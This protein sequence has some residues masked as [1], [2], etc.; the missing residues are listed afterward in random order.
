M[1]E[2]FNFIPNPLHFN[3]V[4]RGVKEGINLLKT[5]YRD[6]EPRDIETAMDIL[7]ELTVLSVCLGR[8]E[9]REEGGLDQAIES[10]T[11][12][13]FNNKMQSRE[14]TAIELLKAVECTLVQIQ[15]A[16]IEELRDITE[17]ERRA[18]SILINFKKELT[19]L[20][21]MS[22]PEW[23]KAAWEIE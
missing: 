20:I 19:N 8:E 12:Y 23:S 9:L 5:I 21:I 6:I 11:R 18:L 16:P 7:R 10:E 3:S 17:D 15:F 2:G 14:L 4:E 1:L 22:I 13:L